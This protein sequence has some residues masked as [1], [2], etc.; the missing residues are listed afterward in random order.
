MKFGFLVLIDEKTNSLSNIEFVRI[1]IRAS[2][3][4]LILDHALEEQGEMAG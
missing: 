4:E 1:R 2:S 3:L